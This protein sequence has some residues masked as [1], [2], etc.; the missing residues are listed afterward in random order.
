MPNPIQAKQIATDTAVTVGSTNAEGTSQS[1]ARA[2]HLHAVDDLAMAGQAQGDVLFFD[3]SNWVVLPAG[4]S[5]EQL[6]TQGAG[7]D[8]IWSA[9]AGVQVTWKDSVQLATTADITLSGEQVI[10]G[11]LTSTSRVLVK[12][13]STASENG[14]YV[15]AAGAWTRST[16]ADSDSEVTCGL[17]AYVCEG[18]A[19]ADSIWSLTTDDPITVGVTSL[20]FSNTSTPVGSAIGQ[21]TYF[22]GSRWVVLAAGTTDQVLTA[23]TGAAPTWETPTTGAPA[24]EQITTENIVGTDTAL[25]DTLSATPISNA[26]VVVYLN[27]VQQIQGAGQDY[28]IAGTTITWLA[29]TGTA[30]DMATTDSMTVTYEA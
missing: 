17:T 30:V 25:A 15:S 21:V 14:I 13:Q 24:Q 12:N 10:D 8:P 9:A 20:A 18:T 2:D 11:V 23:N 22:D 28:T 5:G 6:T 29:S 16:D 7:S 3:G 27:G 4:T 26:S 19:N 1:V